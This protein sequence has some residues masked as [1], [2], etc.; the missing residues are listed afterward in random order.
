MI[1]AIHGNNVTLDLVGY[2]KKHN[3]FNKDQIVKL[4]EDSE[5]LREEISMPEPNVM[6][7]A[8]YEVENVTSE[9]Q[10]LPRTCRVLRNNIAKEIYGSEV[11]LSI[12]IED[13]P[14]MLNETETELVRMLTMLIES[15]RTTKLN[16]FAKIQ[17]EALV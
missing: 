17:K 3:V 13:T 2:P 5:W 1:T 15:E 8:S 6:D 9:V 16:R 7:E 10:R 12:K 11:L 4:Y 14:M